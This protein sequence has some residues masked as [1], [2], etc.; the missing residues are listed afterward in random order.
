MAAEKAQ[1]VVLR[2]TDWSESSRIAT[3][4]TREFGKVRVLAKGG[5]RLK[6]NFENALDLLTVCS[7][8]L[9]RKSSGSLDLLTEAQ[10]VRRFP[11]LRQDLGAL[12]AAYYVAELLA[13]WTEDYDPHP[14]LYEEALATLRALGG[15][16]AEAGS[17][18]GQTGLRI[19]RFE[20]VFLR[21]LGYVPVLE[22]C[23]ACGGPVPGQGL[24]FGPAAGG[25]LC[26]KCQP[27]QRERRPLS[28]PAWEMLRVLAEPGGAWCRPWDGGVRAEVR[29]L[30]GGYVTYLRGRRPRLLPY[31]ES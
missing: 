25:V 30:L 15:D 24:A 12:Y 10:V 27:G 26:P 16:E 2:T 7:I 3:L 20:M 8:V 21:E 13:D 6:S 5:R 14:A 17:A 11:R 4:W 18:P 9:L 19:L 31:L 1:A 28:A 29:Q 22:A 23:A